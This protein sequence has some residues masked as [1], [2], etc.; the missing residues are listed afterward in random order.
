[1]QQTIEFTGEVVDE[2]ALLDGT[3]EL[4]IEAASTAAHADADWQL[5]LSFR[6]PKEMETELE[7]GELSLTGDGAAVYATLRDGTVAEVFDEDTAD[8][9]VRL[10]LTFQVSSGEG[11]LS[12]AAGTVAL[13]GEVVGTQ[14]RL[15]VRLDLD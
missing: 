2:Q 6:W 4:T 15:A 1:M 11:E 8:E 13:S 10:A 12:S 5:S 7:E 3:R 14:V 9:I